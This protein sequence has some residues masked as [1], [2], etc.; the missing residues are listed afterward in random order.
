M[1]GLGLGGRGRPRSW[2]L[3]ERS[4]CGVCLAGG[5]RSPPVLFS[6]Q[7][8]PREAGDSDSGPVGFDPAQL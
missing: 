5:Q 6:V 8:S 1:A 7:I 4:L 2:G 3:Q